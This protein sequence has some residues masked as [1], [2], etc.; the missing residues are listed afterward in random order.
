[1]TPEVD[2]INILKSRQISYRKSPDEAQTHPYCPS[3]SRCVQAAGFCK[4]QLS[5]PSL[6]SSTFQDHNPLSLPL[7]EQH[8]QS[9]I[10]AVS[11][12]ATIL[13]RLRHH[14]NYDSAQSDLEMCEQNCSI[15]G[16][17]KCVNRCVGQPKAS[18]KSNS[19]AFQLSREP[20]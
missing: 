12:A 7:K 8:K 18:F 2:I 13:G 17:K 15:F 5:T 20:D 11:F 19:H 9:I 4:S 16:I 14:G 1:M 10:R 6:R 3:L